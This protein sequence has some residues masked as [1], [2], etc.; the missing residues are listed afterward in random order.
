MSYNLRVGVRVHGTDLYATIATPEF[1][2]P[3]YNLGVMFRMAMDWNFKQGDW[4][5]CVEVFEKIKL[6]IAELT[7]HP[8][9]YKK[10]QMYKDFGS[11][12]QA[13]RDLISLKNCI[14]RQMEEIPL[15]HLY[16]AW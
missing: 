11:I 2:N 1:D 3:T 15:E 14:D 5:P 7:E 12:N 13:K 9:K 16:V 8:E 6:G 4:Y 10:Y